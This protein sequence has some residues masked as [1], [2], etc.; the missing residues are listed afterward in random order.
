M[1][2]RFLSDF[3]MFIRLRASALYLAA[4]ATVATLVFLL[5]RWLWYPGALFPAAGGRDL[6][7]LISGVDLVLGPLIV[8]I[9]YRPGKKGLKFDLAAIGMVQLL[10]LA[11]GIWVLFESR[12]AYIVFI[13][14]RFELVRANDLAEEDLAKVRN[15][16]FARAPRAGPRVVGAL[17]P[18]DPNE[19]FRIGMAAMQGGKDVHLLP[20]YYVPYDELKGDVML[21][22]FPMA[23]LRSLNPSRTAEID[24]LEK[25]L[26]RGDADLRFLPMRAEKHDITVI[27]DNVS[28][29]VV[30]L[31]DLRPWEFK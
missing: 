20:Q 8:F 5:M 29:E 4:T 26:G 21:K 1:A 24:A 17:L 3:P 31:V 2:A 23:R 10:A 6:F 12:P 13:K 16:P 19:Q 22:A 11:S 7:F 30:D 15:G 9:I 25:R 28:A 14:D 27:L 18:K